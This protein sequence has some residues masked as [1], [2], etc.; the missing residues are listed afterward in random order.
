[1]TSVIIQQASNTV[2]SRTS[3]D[4][5]IVVHTETDASVSCWTADDNVTERNWIHSSVALNE[6]F[7]VKNSN[8]QLWRISD[9]AAKVAKNDTRK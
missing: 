7:G 1:M 9:D 4:L 5:C 2:L 6:K 8:H 3:A